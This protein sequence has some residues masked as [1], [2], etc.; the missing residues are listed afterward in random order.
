MHFKAF[1]GFK[2][3]RV[4]LALPVLKDHKAVVVK[5]ALMDSRVVMA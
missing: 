3:L 5:L 1:K 4:S 2:G